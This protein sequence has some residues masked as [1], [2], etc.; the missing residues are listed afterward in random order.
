MC[1]CNTY[2]AATLTNW[3]TIQRI[4]GDSVL[5][6]DRVFYF[7]FLG[8]WCLYLEMYDFYLIWHGP[9]IN[10][11][12]IF[13][14][15]LR[16]TQTQ[17]LFFVLEIIDRMQR[18][19]HKAFHIINCECMKGRRVCELIT[20]GG[21]AYAWQT[22]VCGLWP[23]DGGRRAQLLSADLQEFFQWPFWHRFGR[24]QRASIAHTQWPRFMCH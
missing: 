11:L 3:L 19:M 1:M 24:S 10:V 18:E 5:W 13:L 7:F 4:C 21:F 6:L 15:P 23:M 8:F 22:R 9:R 20:T 16:F 12:M 14:N 17:I 2:S